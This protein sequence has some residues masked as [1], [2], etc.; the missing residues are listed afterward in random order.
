MDTKQLSMPII[1]GVIV[2]AIAVVLGGGF[3]YTNKTNAHKP[4]DLSGVAA[5]MQVQQKQDA[6]AHTQAK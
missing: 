2:I 3:Y 1:I 4:A 6:A 5:L